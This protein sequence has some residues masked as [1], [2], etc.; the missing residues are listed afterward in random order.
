MVAYLATC[1]ISIASHGSATDV[2]TLESKAE[3]KLGPKK[4]VKTIL[5]IVTKK[6]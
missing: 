4:L 2:E 5:S 6:I 1:K 3:S